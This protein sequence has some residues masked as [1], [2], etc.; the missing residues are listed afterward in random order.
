MYAD[1]PAPAMSPAAVGAAA[2]RAAAFQVADE[3]GLYCIDR[4]RRDLIERDTA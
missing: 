2:E 1:M 3:I 4:L